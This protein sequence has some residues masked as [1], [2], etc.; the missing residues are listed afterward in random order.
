MENVWI[1]I[2]TPVKNGKLFFDD[3]VSSI[4]SQ[5]INPKWRINVYLMDDGSTDGFDYK[6]ALNAVRSHN[7]YFYKSDSSLG[8][9]KSKNLLIY[10]AIKNNEQYIFFHDID[11]IW[12]EN[13]V[14]IQIDHMLNM[15]SNFSCTL[16]SSRRKFDID[17]SSYDLS[18]I[19]LG[20]ILCRRQIYFSSVCLSVNLLKS[21]N[22]H[23]KIYFK[24]FRAEDYGLWI[25]LYPYM[26]NPI[27]INKVLLF[28]R[29]HENQLSR[30]KLKQFNAVFIMYFKYLGPFA[31]FPLL[32]YA[33]NK[34]IHN[35][36]FKKNK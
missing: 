17:N 1:G 26:K 14:S 9:S 31:F 13:K 28:Y 25:K 36:P 19:T 22:T 6:L 10:E 18:K 27:L 33:I 11:D 30:N 12:Y 23:D 32:I 21:L 5:V 34:I 7:K 20:N 29:I 35:I 8:V 15:K 4:N 3:W 2:I 24:G 16:A